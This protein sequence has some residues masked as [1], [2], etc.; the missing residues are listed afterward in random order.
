MTNNLIKGLIVE[1]THI[2]LQPS[3][4]YGGAAGLIIYRTP[5]I[6][7][8]FSFLLRRGVVDITMALTKDSIV[9]AQKLF[10]DGSDYGVSLRYKLLDEPSFLAKEI[11][12][13]KEY[14]RGSKM[15]F[16][17]A[18]SVLWGKEMRKS[19]TALISSDFEQATIFGKRIA[20]PHSHE[21]MVLNLCGK[22]LSF[23]KC[24]ESDNPD[25]SCL[26]I[27][28]VGFYPNDIVEV[29]EGLSESYI[30]KAHRPINQTYLNAGNLRHI[31]LHAKEIWTE[32]KSYDSIHR[33]SNELY[34]YFNNQKIIVG[35]P[36]L[37]AVLSGLIDDEQFLKIIK[38]YKG[39]DYYDLLVENFTK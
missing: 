38:K 20:T 16:I 30:Y 4:S 33:L 2:N 13:D 34:E 1:T 24:E 26:S 10:G 12:A 14:Y 8:P 25:Y 27:P 31:F 36:E 19:T 3:V 17:S 11:M 21:T 39:T 18:N 29:V 9:T 28:K 22:I 23:D 35:S 7:F 15:I 6:C 37:N 32:I 5:L